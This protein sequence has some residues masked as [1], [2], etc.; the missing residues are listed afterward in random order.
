MAG[1]PTSTQEA[2]E[3]AGQG[4]A[5]KL[6]LNGPWLLRNDR[7]ALE[8]LQLRRRV[9]FGQHIPRLL[10]KDWIAPEVLQLRLQYFFGQHIPFVPHPKHLQV[11][12]PALSALH[13]T[14][15]LSDLKS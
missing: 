7:V 1:L 2:T 13:T 3:V 8:M 15:N 4:S 12:T 10:H 6:L 11:A 14:K 5:P 9:L